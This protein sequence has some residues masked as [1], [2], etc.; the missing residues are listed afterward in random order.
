VDVPAVINGRSDNDRDTD[1][2]AFHAEAGQS[3]V[4]EIQAR[5]FGSPLDSILTLF[6]A[7]GKPLA[8]YDDPAPQA[9]P[10]ALGTGV[11]NDMGVSVRPHEALLLHRADARMVHTFESAGEYTVRVADVTEMGGSEYAYRL[12]IAPAEPD[13]ILRVK[14]DAASVGTGDSALVALNVLRENDFDAPVRVQVQDV[15]AGFTASEA[16]IPAGETDAHLTIAVPV[17]AAP[18]FYSPKL[19]AKA[20]IDG[21]TIERKGIPVET[22][23]QAFYIKHLVPTQ[24]FLLHV[25]QPMFYS[26]SSDVPP[27]KALEIAPGGQAKIVVK[28]QRLEGA[29][30]PI[31]IA[32]VSSPAGISVKTAQI[33]PAQEQVELTISA[34]QQAATDTTGYLILTGTAN[35][36]KQ[37]IVRVLPAIP[38]NIVPAS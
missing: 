28:A 14:T 30:G 19:V 36:G 8:Q 29:K 1:C 18:G 22:V 38:V 21:N 10:N 2:F 6:D 15:P 33:G 7:T 12:R 20:E 35:V 17:E 27:S 4:L 16:I 23:G 25:G 5:R 3:L 31:S 37:S 34:T 26:L 24:E 11:E 9:V 32:A 13:F